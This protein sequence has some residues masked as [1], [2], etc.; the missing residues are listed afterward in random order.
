MGEAE[1]GEIQSRESMGKRVQIVDSKNN[2]FDSTMAMFLVNSI[3]EELLLVGILNI[4][5]D[6]ED[7]IYID[8]E[9]RIYGC[10]RQFE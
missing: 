7:S 6:K 1:G 8:S 2:I 9:G 10:S 3:S 5:D 4:E